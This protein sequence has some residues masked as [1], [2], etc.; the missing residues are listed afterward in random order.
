[1][2]KRILS[3]AIAAA[4]AVP[5]MLPNQVFAQATLEEI[6]VTAQRRAEDLQ[7]VPVAVTSFNPEELDRLGVTDPQQMADFIPNVSIGD[8]TGRA[9]VGAQFSIRGV[10]EARISPV[11]DPAV[12]IY[13]DE[14]YY[15]RPITNFLRL[16]DV[17]GVEVLR[18]PQ[19]TLFGKNST[20]GAI[21]YTTVKPDVG[22]EMNGY[23]KAGFG[24]FSRANLRT[25]LNI[26][27][28]DT[29][30]ARVS[31]SHMERDGWVDRISD[32]VGLGADDTDF[33]SAKLRYQP[34]EKFTVDVGLDYTESTSN[35]GASKLID[36]FGYN[37][38]F[39][40]PATP[41]VEGDI[42]APIFTSGISNIAA[43]NVLFPVGTPENYA[44]T[45]PRDLYQIAGTGPI[46]GTD[47][48]STGFSMAISYEIS[49]T[50]T[51]R[52]ITGYRDMET[53]EN[54]E[55]DESSF[56]E[57]FFDSKTLDNSD[58]WSQEIQ[59]TGLAFDGRLNYVVGAYIS[60][61]EPTLRQ[62]A[63]RDYRAGNKFG[64][65]ESL[66][67][68]AQL[69]ESSGI[70]AQA[71]WMLSDSL[72]LTLGVRSVEDKKSFSTFNRG[73]F[74]NALD[75]RL[76]EIWAIDPNGP[77]DNSNYPDI[78]PR[79]GRNV[80]YPNGDGATFGGCTAANPCFLSPAN[81]IVGSEAA[82]TVSGS[83]TFT[84]VTPR[85]ALEWQAKDNMMFYASA[86]K[87]FKAGGTNDTVADI[88]TPFNRKNCGIMNWVLDCSQ[89]MAGLEL[90]SPYSKWIIPISN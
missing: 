4:V 74:D 69:T 82:A 80:L 90:I 54:R 55:S 26:P 64:T 25:A 84:T 7:S 33:F 17:Q 49:D 24:E 41:G 1:M 40:D 30:A 28:S 81:S 5:V 9:N 51:F 22:G 37:G 56:A 19:G 15:G 10:N 50:L 18:G 67:T 23:V 79:P 13:I 62:L 53:L 68:R 44:P 38:G 2:K 12:G 60:E 78:D 65:L 34:N 83:D 66:G 86:T 46:G 42:T 61:E 71:D 57:S 85:V 43:Y 77:D 11:L 87:G 75:Q 48:Q 16:L 63:N 45:I 58:F 73:V 31:Y 88:D 14:V 72:T 21:V 32:G 36:Y 47:A 27:L 3:V 35:G 20:G 29:L 8:G 89:R 6:T 52:S 39:D 76:F 70:F 59:L